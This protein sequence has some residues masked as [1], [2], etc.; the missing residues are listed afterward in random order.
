MALV[1]S[2]WYG[3]YLA[4]SQGNPDNCET[5]LVFIQ[6]SVFKP[7]QAKYKVST[8]EAV[9]ARY[10]DVFKKTDNGATDESFRKVKTH[11]WHRFSTD[12]MVSTW[13]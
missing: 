8:F 7:F 6:S 1:F 11:L 12:G 5:L 10:K 2:R 9:F 3:L 4:V 13:P